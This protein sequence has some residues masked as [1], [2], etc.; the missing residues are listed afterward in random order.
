MA[1]T[2]GAE[3]VGHAY[4]GFYLLAMGS[5]RPRTAAELRGLLARAGFNRCREVATSLP[6]LLR[7]LVAGP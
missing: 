1:E 3:P 5:G 2:P 4:F 7:I 6:L